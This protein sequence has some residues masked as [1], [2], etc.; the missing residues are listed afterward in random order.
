MKGTTTTTY[1]KVVVNTGI[2]KGKPRFEKHLRLDLWGNPELRK[3]FKNGIEKDKAKA[4]AALA[5][6]QSAA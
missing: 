5:R 2:F 4:K 1:K 6:K 3:F